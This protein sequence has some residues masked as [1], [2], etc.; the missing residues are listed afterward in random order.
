MNTHARPGSAPF[1]A[2][3]HSLGKPLLG[4]LVAG[5]II[6]TAIGA[7]V[8]SRGGSDEVVQSPQPPV[9]VPTPAPQLAEHERVHLVYIVSDEERAHLVQAAIDEANVYRRLDGLPPV[10]AT[11]LAADTEAEAVQMKEAFIEGNRI[12]AGLGL[13]EDIVVDF[14]GQ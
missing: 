9:T 13:P 3:R 5:V 11:V 1:G 8:W 7:G 2:P 6:L 4:V 10:L 14:R 12:L